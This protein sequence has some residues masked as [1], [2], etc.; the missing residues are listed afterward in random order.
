M[1]NELLK[2]EIALSDNIQIDDSFIIYL[3]D[4]TNANYNIV[5]NFVERR[6]GRQQVER[7]V[8]LQTTLG[9]IKKSFE[10]DYGLNFNIGD[11]IE[12]KIEVISKNPG[13]KYIDSLKNPTLMPI[14][15]VPILVPVNTFKIEKV[16]FLPSPFDSCSIVVID[17]TTNFPTVRYC[18]NNECFQSNS[19]R[20]NFFYYRGSTCKLDMYDNL[21][22][23][24]TVNIKTPALI[25]TSSNPITLNVINGISGGTLTVNVPFANELLYQFSLDNVNWQQKNIFEGLSKGNYILYVQDNFSCKKQLSFTVLENNFGSPFAFLS[26]ENSIRFIEP[27]EGYNTDENRSFCNS[28]AKIN[29]GFVQ[30]FLNSDI[31]TTQF[32]SNFNDINVHVIDQLSGSITFIPLN[33]LSNNI[34]LKA[35]YNQVKKYKISNTQF[36]I[37]FESGQILDYDNNNVI[38]SYELNG[39]LPIWAK[40]GNV[41]QIDSAYFIIESIGFDENVNA[42]VLIFNGIGPTVTQNTTVRCEYNNQNYE[43]YEFVIDLFLFKNSSIKIEIV[44]SDPNFGEYR[45]ISEVIE[46]SEELPQTLEI[47][48]FNTINTNVV[49]STGIQHLL[50]LPYNTTKANDSD[51]SES[52]KTDTNTNLLNSDVYEITDIE[53]MPLP[54]E[55]YRKLKI[56][57]SMD[58][59]FID[60]VGYTKSSEFN[61]ENLGSSNLYKLTASMIKNGFVFNSNRDNSEIITDGVINVPGLIVSQVTGYIEY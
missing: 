39:S 47:R 8:D 10:L 27:F 20:F 12:N 18:V 46:T 44:N 4:E 45:W 36:G 22:N 6:I 50:R 2:I 54:L 16:E 32:K 25:E 42:E 41:I 3:K 13:W 55:L 35:K 58:S 24:S 48:Y 15:F 9:N 29:Y 30:Q 57:L 11:V 23:K 7:G 21:G 38:D 51:S 56:A 28:T 1:E 19:N 60:G 26:K 49:Y 14:E 17:I 53:F 34:G 31:I 33:K 37:Y 43:V 5:A 52:Y 61:K 59:V 40:L